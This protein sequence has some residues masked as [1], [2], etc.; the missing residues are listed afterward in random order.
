MIIGGKETIGENTTKSHSVMS[1]VHDALMIL[2]HR[3][4]GLRSEFGPSSSTS[5]VKGDDAPLEC[6]KAP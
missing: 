5:G 2:V 6:D 4:S 1:P 3:T